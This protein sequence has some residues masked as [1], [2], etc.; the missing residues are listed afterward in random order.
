MRFRIAFL[1]LFSATVINAQNWAPV[2]SGITGSSPNTTWSLCAYDSVLFAGGWFTTAG[3]AT[4]NSLAQ[5][6]GTNWDSLGAGTDGY[7]NAMAVYLDTLYAGGLFSKIGGIAASNVAK[8]NGINWMPAGA[9]LKGGDYGIYAMAVYNDA[10]YVAGSFD[11]SGSKAIF[12]IAR[13]NDT[14]WSALDNQIYSI[15]EDDAVFALAVYKGE[16]YIGGDF[17]ISGGSNIAAWNGTTM[18]NVGGGTTGNIY[19]LAVY[20]N[21]LYVGGMITQAG[22]IQANCIAAWNTSA[23]SSP[24]SGI[25]GENT[26]ALVNALTVYNGELY[27][28]G[29]FDTVNGQAINCIAKWNGS[30]W[31][32]VGSGINVGGAIDAM[33]VYH[34]SLYVGGGFDSAGGVSAKNIAQWSMP[35]AINKLDESNFMEIYPNPNNGIFTLVCHSEQ[36]EESLQINV[37]TISGEQLLTET[38]RYSQGDNLIDLTGQPCGIYILT[39]CDANKQYTARLIKD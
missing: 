11:S 17:A 21:Q 20:N 34:N 27:A 18:S 38:L 4:A 13:W 33:T 19:S 26:Y 24:D 5:W 16:L 3:G 10:L 32:P 35:S 31:S 8:W 30:K 6:N 2:S 12:G 37:Y 1:L 39:V 29:F 14:N 22:A 28:G 23:W 9:G 7:I 15:E 25:W 36:R